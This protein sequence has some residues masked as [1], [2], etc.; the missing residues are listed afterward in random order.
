[1][2]FSNT[3]QKSENISL[4]SSRGIVSLDLLRGLAAYLVI[5]PHF[6]LFMGYDLK[7]LEFL[8]AFSVEIF[9]VLSGFVLGPQL[10]N[11]F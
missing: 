9:F 8:A 1:M 11:I 10:E 2:T 6:F 5:I 3:L 4:F 7:P